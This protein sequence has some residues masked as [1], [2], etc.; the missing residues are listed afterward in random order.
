VTTKP[1]RR[2]LIVG[3]GAHA[4]AVADVAR[5]CGW[6]V[7]GFLGA[8]AVRAGTDVIG[9][10]DDL[11]TLAEARRF[12]AATVGVGNTALARRP[13]LFGQLRDLGVIAPAL[14]HPS[15]V[16]SP[17]VTIGDGSVVFPLVVVGAD[18]IIGENVV[19]YS[20]AIVEHNCRI[21]DHAYLSPGVVL[22]GNVRVDAGAFVGAGAVA[23]PGVTIA[24][25]A[26]VA[27]GAR[28]TDTR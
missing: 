20:G 13:K 17:S 27:A 22:C 16:I 3:A 1:G 2:L 18:A 25:D 8:R 11:R 9:S 7:I 5:A 23:V 21:A 6:S 26:V 10:D 15:A 19:L 24:K 4:R 14:V 12:D 28:V